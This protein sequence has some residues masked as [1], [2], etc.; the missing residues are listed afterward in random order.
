[1][2]LIRAQSTFKQSNEARRRYP[3]VVWERFRHPRPPG[4]QG[5]VELTK[6]LFA[7]LHERGFNSKNAF[8]EAEI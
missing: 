1:M 5:V 6:Y 8:S 3:H 2:P 4:P 7:P